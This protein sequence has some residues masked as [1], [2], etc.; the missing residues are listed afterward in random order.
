MATAPFLLVSYASEAEAWIWAVL[1][2]LSD[3]SLIF[4]F[5][6][7]LPLSTDIFWLAIDVGD[8]RE[9]CEWRLGRLV[10]GL[11]CDRFASELGL[12]VVLLLPY[13]AE[14]TWMKTAGSLKSTLR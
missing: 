6:P 10:I 3:E 13:W 8:I 7:T 14:S 12:K 11:T 5:L 9:G 2:E 4:P 1:R